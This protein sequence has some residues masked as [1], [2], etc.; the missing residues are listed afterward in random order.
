MS[1]RQ[2]SSRAS[3]LQL[4]GGDSPVENLEE[5]SSHQKSPQRPLMMTQQAPSPRQ[6]QNQDTTH[7]ASS[8]PQALSR[9]NSSSGRASS[10][11]GLLQEV[12]APKEKV[13]F[14]LLVR[15]RLELPLTL[16]FAGPS[17]QFSS[18]E[19]CATQ[20]KLGNEFCPRKSQ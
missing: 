16:I 19:R 7:T 20:C 14:S 10:Q 13:F 2:P 17:S 12:G 18:V 3:S 1:S 15:P 11:R 8:I 4:G 9:R 5:P 6:Q